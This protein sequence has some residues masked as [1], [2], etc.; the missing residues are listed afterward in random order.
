[1]GASDNSTNTD[2][3]IPVAHEDFEGRAVTFKLNYIN[4]VNMFGFS[5][6][7]SASITSTGV[8]LFMF[9]ARTGIW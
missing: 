2:V 6:T 8:S 1:V 5:V 7:V 4:V 3:T 9:E